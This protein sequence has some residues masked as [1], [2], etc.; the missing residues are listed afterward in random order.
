MCRGRCRSQL[1]G[2]L[3]QPT[4]PVHLAGLN[5]SP[6]SLPS[7][8][9]RWERR[10]GRGPDSPWLPGPR[11][12]RGEGLLRTL[13]WKSLCSHLA[14]L[15]PTSVQPSCQ[16]RCDQGRSAEPQPA[17]HRENPASLRQ[18]ERP[19]PP[20]TCF[21]MTSVWEL[22]VA[23]RV[24]A[25]LSLL[26]RSG[27]NPWPSAVNHIEIISSY[28]VAVLFQTAWPSASKPGVEYREC[29]APASITNH[30]Y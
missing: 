22:P 25:V 23:Q 17:L 14:G 19:R 29:H 16:K 9:P 24:T 20:P 3:S 7:S 18:A 2:H 8:P 1:L 4:I 6:A 26:L 15:S 21:E 10:L 12:P 5:K 28:K 13:S 30:C 27:C 11:Q